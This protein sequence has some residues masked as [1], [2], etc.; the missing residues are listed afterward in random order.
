LSWKEPDFD[1]GSEVTGYYVE[2]RQA[3]TSRWT[4]VN[5]TATTDTSLKISDLIEGDEYEFRV[6]AENAAGV[7]KPSDTTGSLIARDPYDKPDK[8]GRP[9]VSLDKDSVTLTWTKP[10]NDGRS[11]IFNYVIEMKA[12]GDVR[13]KVVNLQEKCTSTTFIVTKLQPDINYEFRVSAENKAGVGMP[14]SPSNRVM[15]GKSPITKYYCGITCVGK[16]CIYMYSDK[17]VKIM[18]CMGLLLQKRS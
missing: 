13:W 8:P 14:S 9:D 3:F 2:R 11:K 4:K 17:W 10:L 18:L 16:Y 12:Q 1:G 6:V 7:S 15:Y 5:K